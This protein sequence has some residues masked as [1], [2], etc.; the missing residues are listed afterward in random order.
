MQHLVPMNTIFTSGTKSRTFSGNQTL[1][2]FII[3]IVFITFYTT[4]FI[5][6]YTLHWDIFP[7]ILQQNSSVHFHS[8][9]LDEVIFQSS[10][11]REENSM[12]IFSTS[13][14]LPIADYGKRTSIP[15]LSSLRSKPAEKGNLQTFHLRQ[16][17][18][19]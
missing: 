9:D 17:K 5:I 7:T 10:S 2:R 14:R 3:F 19:W 12:Q 15:T 8:L 6:R 1:P 16:K 4:T 13:F 11:P 18:L